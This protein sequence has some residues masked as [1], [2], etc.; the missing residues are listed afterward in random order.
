MQGGLRGAAALPA[1]IK[2]TWG[3]VKLKSLYRYKIDMAMSCFPHYKK[4]EGGGADENF[5]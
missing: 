2:C 1:K 3:T 5:M 4:E